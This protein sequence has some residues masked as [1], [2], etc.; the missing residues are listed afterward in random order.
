M[1]NR[2]AKLPAGQSRPLPQD[3]DAVGA[4]ITLGRHM[5]QLDQRMR[6]VW[7]IR[8][9]ASDYQFQRAL[10]EL[11]DQMIQALDLMSPDP[12]IE[13]DTP[14]E[15]IG[16]E[17]PSLGSTQMVNQERWPEGGAVD[18]WNIDREADN[19]DKE[20][21]LGSLAAQEWQSQE[22]WAR[23]GSDDRETDPAESGIADQGGLAEQTGGEPSMGS[24]DNMIDQTKAWRTHDG[25]SA[26]WACDESEVGANSPIEKLDRMRARYRAKRPHAFR[27]R[28]GATVIPLD[29]R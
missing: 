14:R 16:D 15:P 5:E 11:I 9:D 6:V 28:D 1:T 4:I 22:Q 3:P 25:P 21:C 18:E 29:R 17:E 26:W 20:P 19:A 10:E 2:I 23:G 12:D 24:F 7:Q 13:E 8:P 27:L